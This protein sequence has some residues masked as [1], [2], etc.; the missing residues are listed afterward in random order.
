[1][2]LVGACTYYDGE[3]LYLRIWDIDGGVRDTSSHAW[4]AHSGLMALK[5]TRV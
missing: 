3:Q 2:T 5:R 1:M 4:M